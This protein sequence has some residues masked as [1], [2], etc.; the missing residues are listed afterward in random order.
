MHTQE[1]QKEKGKQVTKVAGSLPAL[2]PLKVVL[3]SQELDVCGGKTAHYDKDGKPD[4]GLDQSAPV[5]HSCLTCL[6]PVPGSLPH[7]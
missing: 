3:A 2:F 7:P 4:E 6:S 5:C 1:E